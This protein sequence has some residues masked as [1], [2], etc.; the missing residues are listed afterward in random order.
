MKEEDVFILSKGHACWPLYVLLMEKGLFP[1]LEGH[2]HRDPANGISWTTGSLGHGFPAA[3]GMALARKV[4]GKDGKVF[5]LLGDGECQEGTTW[6]SILIASKLE[7]NNLLVIVD[8]NGIQGSCRELYS[9]SSVLND[10]A[11]AAGWFIFSVN[12]HDL[13]EMELKMGLALE[14]QVQPSLMI[15]KTVKGAGISFMEDSPEWHAK[16]PDPGMVD[17]ILGELE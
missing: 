17:S 4:Q 15:A 5:V 11:E 6:E 9:V 3:I 14:E 13:Y 16:Y 1:R 7:L 2:P 12:G 8:S 10:A